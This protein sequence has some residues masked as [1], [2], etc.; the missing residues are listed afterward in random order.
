M[1]ML[2]TPIPNAHLAR[3]EDCDPAELLGRFEYCLKTGSKKTEYG[4][5][6]DAWGKL[7]SDLYLT[8]EELVDEM[9][10]GKHRLS[11][12]QESMLREFVRADCA[13]VGSFVVKVIKNGGKI[14]RAALI[15]LADLEELA[16]I[17]YNGM[18]AIH[19]LVDACDKK[20]RPTLIRK[21]GKRLLSQVYDR[22][23]IPTIFL[24]FSLVD[25]YGDDLDAIAG[26]FS[27]DE[28]R[29]IM[30]KSRTGNNALDVLRMWPHC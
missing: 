15:M 22:R 17:E 1:K 5:L 9:S 25:I 3:L 16:G 10:H 26:I 12:D 21:M 4:L 29:N 19:L 6:A 20:I 2:R 28:L 14:D 30:S 27:N 8:P 13:N 24:I 23:G 18:T 7:F 11:G